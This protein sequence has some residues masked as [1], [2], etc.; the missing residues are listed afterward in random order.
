VSL[1][2]R[3]EHLKRSRL[4]ERRGAETY[5]GSV[6]SG[7]GNGWIRKADVRTEDE[8]IECKTTT[9]TSYSLKARELFKLWQQAVIDNRTP[10]FEIEF[11]GDGMSCVV[12]DKRDYLLMREQAAYPHM[13]EEYPG[14]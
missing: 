11:A 9:K 3:N 10:V 7:S 5:N 12:L 14:E 4:Q 8:L 1:P 6:N 2:K 13:P